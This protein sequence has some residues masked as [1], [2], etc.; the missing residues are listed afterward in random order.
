MISRTAVA[1]VSFAILS[2]ITNFQAAL[3]ICEMA[4]ASVPRIDFAAFETYFEP[5]RPELV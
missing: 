4:E 5:L 2:N 3:A 1:A